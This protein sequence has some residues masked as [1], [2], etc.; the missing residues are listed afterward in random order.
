MKANINLEINK[1][2]LNY[3][4]ECLVSE[5]ASDQVEKMVREQATE[6]VRE[7]VEKIISPIVDSYLKTAIVGEEYKS[8]H[9]DKPPRTEVDQYIKRTLQNYLDEPCFV[10]D[11][12]SNKLSKKYMKSSDGDRTTRA[13]HWIMDKAREYADKELFSKI[14]S[15]IEETIKSVIPTGEQIQE[16]IKQEIQNKFNQEGVTS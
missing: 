12:N 15:Q 10:F 6:M 5:V 1:E 2:D 9:S 14:D 7:E 11:K 16:I 8:F 13:E 4:L 3:E